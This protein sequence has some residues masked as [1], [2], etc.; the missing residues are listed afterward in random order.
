VAAWGCGRKSAE[1]GVRGSRA[2]GAGTLAQVDDAELRE[3]DLRQLIP[4]D[5]RESI[6]GSEIRAILDRWIAVQLLY[7]RALDE[8]L[9]E[10]PEV[11]ETL[12][13]T[14]R[15]ILAD[16]YLQRELQKRVRVTNEEIQ[17]YYD[18]HRDEYTQ[19]VHLRHILVDT[20]EEAE[21]IL[22]ELRAGGDFRAL[23]QKHST[24]PTASRGG[25]LGY[26]GKG[27]M[28]PAFEPEVFR[29]A[30]GEV[31]GPIA[32]AFGFHLVQVVRRRRAP[33]PVTFDVARDEIMQ[34]LLLEKQRQA[35]REL[36]AELR[37]SANVFQAKSYAG[38][39]LEPDTS[40]PETLTDT[41]G[42]EPDMPVEDTLGTEP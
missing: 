2:P 31:Q 7:Q 17:E 37:A 32:S 18:A 10:D 15:Q 25:D 5:Y 21:Q 1:D 16:E 34:I 9:E 23:A 11:A 29:M 22:A 12:Q 40:V 42:S 39:A 33:E 6:T 41:G 19:E 38:M 30:A 28:N 13:Q 14:R 35:E 24:D 8:G 27:A 36:F 4:P 26:L 20:P 3:E